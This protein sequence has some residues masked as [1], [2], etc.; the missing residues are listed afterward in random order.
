MDA[1]ASSIVTSPGGHAGWRGFSTEL[2][3]VLSAL[4]SL[5][6][7]LVED[8]TLGAT[9]LCAGSV[10]LGTM[11]LPGSVAATG[12]AVASAAAV[13][14]GEGIGTSGVGGS[15]GSAAGSCSMGSAAKRT[16][17]KVVG[18]GVGGTGGAAPTSIPLTCES[19]PEAR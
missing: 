11:A 19:H 13:G 6:T 8:A 14:A 7:P 1:R 10:L 17:G 15:C 3:S 16:R 9:P 4:P 5:L 2:T 18:I 12:E